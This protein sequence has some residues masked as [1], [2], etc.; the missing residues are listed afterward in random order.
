MLTKTEAIAAKVRGVSAE[1]RFTQQ[2]MADTL[3]IS[4][5]SVVERM[6]GRVAW[7]APELFALSLAM[8]QPIGRFFPQP[9][10]VSA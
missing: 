6:Q 2:R 9:S 10:E 4:R 5:T 1:S 3:G 8:R 7:S